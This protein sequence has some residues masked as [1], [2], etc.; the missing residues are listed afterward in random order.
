MSY[1]LF[2]RSRC[3]EH[4]LSLEYF[5]AYFNRRSNYEI[6]DDQA[7]YLNQNTDIYF[8]FSY[9]VIS[10]SAEVN[11][12]PMPAGLTP[13]SFRLNVFRPHVFGL[14][15]EHE[16]AEFIDHF[17]LMVYDGQS[18]GRGE[19]EYSRG[20]FLRSYN[21]TNEF[22]YKVIVNTVPEY[23][24]SVVLPTDQIEAVWRWNYRIGEL[25]KII[26]VDIFIPRISYL[27][28]GTDIK[29]CVVWGD[30]DPIILP[31]VDVILLHRSV[32]PF[33]RPNKAKM[34]T[35]I[36]ALGDIESLLAEFPRGKQTMSYYRLEY[37]TVPSAIAQ[38]FE[39]AR[40]HH[41]GE[42]GIIE[43]SSVLNKEILERAGVLHL[44]V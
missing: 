24:K 14:E 19:A 11:D 35:P 5:L 10:E 8:D 29:T 3:S 21:A 25:S 44:M 22:A 20:D 31:E 27:R 15:A 39:D 40:P 16:L 6:S 13:V 36:V 4:D 23:R 33:R 12:V 7:F 28:L 30:G 42:I 17:D 43:P 18:K 32:H 38:F 34:E 26:G 41:S 37:S 9:E 2:F 1:D